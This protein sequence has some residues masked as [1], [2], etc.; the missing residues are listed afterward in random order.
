M[1]SS[2]CEVFP[3]V[4]SD[5]EVSE[6]F[7]AEEDPHLRRSV[8]GHCLVKLLLRESL[9]CSPVFPVKCSQVNI[10]LTK[11]NKSQEQTLSENFL[12]QF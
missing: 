7:S 5:G 8:T 4:S 11:R 1:S 10:V 3:I 12:T 2:G 6:E 9:K